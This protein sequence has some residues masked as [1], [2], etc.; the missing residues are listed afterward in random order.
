MLHLLNRIRI[1]LGIKNGKS[2][3]SA[4]QVERRWK[5]VWHVPD[6][7]T[8]SLDN[9]INARYPP[10]LAG[11]PSAPW[12]PVTLEGYEPGR[13]PFRY[14]TLAQ[15]LYWH[16]MLENLDTLLLLI[17]FIPLQAFEGQ[18]IS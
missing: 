2:M 15:V 7:G 18:V 9:D 8:I 4:S 1:E 3:L 12:S 11:G 6:G 14:L 17:S 13:H 16:K 10:N 5:E